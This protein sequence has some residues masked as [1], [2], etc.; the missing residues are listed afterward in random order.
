[1]TSRLLIA[2]VALACA[3]T[4][5]AAAP[6]A[7]VRVLERSPLTVA[8][9]GFAARELV[10]VT[11]L[12]SLGLRSTSVRAGE[13]GS[14]RASLGRFAQPCGQPVAVRARGLA[15]RRLAVVSLM[16]LPCVP[17]PVR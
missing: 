12:T 8:G 4:A 9:S 15:S 10:A 5:A 14:F 7:V 16:A 2:A 13:R 17:P 3:A 6:R 11:V 1:M